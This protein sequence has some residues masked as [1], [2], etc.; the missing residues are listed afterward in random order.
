VQTENSTYTTYDSGWIL[1]IRP[2]MTDKARRVLLLIHGWT[3]DENSMWVFARQLPDDYLVLAP[4]G[5]VS[6]PSGYG[7]AALEGDKSPPIQAYLD[8]SNRL[9]DQTFA[10]LKAH[11]IDLETPIHLMGFSQGA[12]MCYSILTQRPGQIAKVAG[13]SGFLPGGT[14][15]LLPN[16]HLTGK[17]IFIAHGAKDETIAI[18]RAQDTVRVLEQAGAKVFYCEEDVGHKLGAA[19]FSGLKDFLQ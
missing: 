6:A 3:G 1:R 17:E 10:W 19:C 7:W 13:L 11:K 18:K 4:R 8:I 5:P 16:G 14:E 15:L 2:A 12:A 9:M